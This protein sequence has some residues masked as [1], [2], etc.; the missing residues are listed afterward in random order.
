MNFCTKWLKI[1]T[2]FLACLQERKRREKEFDLNERFL[3]IGVQNK[4]LCKKN[5]HKFSNLLIKLVLKNAI[6]STATTIIWVFFSNLGIYIYIKQYVVPLVDGWSDNLF[7]L[8]FPAVP[9]GT[10]G[11]G[12]VGGGPCLSGGKGG[13]SADWL[14]PVWRRSRPSS[15]LVIGVFGAF[16]V[17][18]SLAWFWEIIFFFF[19]F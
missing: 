10:G 3:R 7:W 5:G 16:G 17:V 19:S 2:I 13:F 4:V 6:F 8:V 11:G 12:V 18:A 14:P 15:S 1:Q 9:P